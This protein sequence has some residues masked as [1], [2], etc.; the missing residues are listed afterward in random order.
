MEK[1]ARR[2]TR[3]PALHRLNQNRSNVGAIRP[4]PRQRIVAAVIEHDEILHRALRNSGRDRS[5][6]WTE[7]HFVENPVIGTTEDD[8]AVASGDRAADAQRRSNRLAAGITKCDT[9]QTKVTPEPLREHTCERRC[10]P[11]FDSGIELPL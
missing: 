7:K 8:H 9:L 11:D 2:Q 4:Q 3:I 10:R 6:T 1:L 5:R